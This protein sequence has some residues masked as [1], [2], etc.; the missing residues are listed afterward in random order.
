MHEK[1]VPMAVGLPTA[2]ERRF[3]AIQHKLFALNIIVIVD[4]SFLNHFFYAKKQRQNNCFVCLC[5]WMLRR[6]ISSFATENITKFFPN[7][8]F[9]L[10]YECRNFR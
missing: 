4:F 9:F 5:S 10:L 6:G 2:G 8:V 3:V 1:L 7:W